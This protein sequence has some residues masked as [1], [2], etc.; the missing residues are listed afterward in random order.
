M[1]KKERWGKK[2]KDKRDWKIYNEELVIRGE[3]YFEFEFLENW[4]KELDEM[5][6]GKA[7]HPYRYPN[8]LFEYL[9]PMYCFLDSRKLEGALRK[10]SLYVRKLKSCDHSTIC[11]RLSKLN[12]QIQ[13]DKSKAYDIIFDS[14]GNK[15]TNRGEYMRHKWKVYRGWIKVSITI[16]KKSKDLLDVEVSLEN[17]ED[18]ELAR[19]HLTNLE[20]IKINSGTGD[21]AYYREELYNEFDRRG[22]IPV[23]KPRSDACPNGLDPMHKAAREFHKLGGYGE[24]RDKYEYGKRWHVEGKISS[25]KRCNGECVRMLNEENFL[26]EAKRKFTDYERMR[27]YAQERIKLLA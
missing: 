25:T 3:F 16:D 18:Y 2:F 27:K 26:K 17:V 10:L 19:K 21:G 11:E 6:K 22:I 24:W 14:T 1:P 15:L 13:L 7:G 8:S 5:N 23:L 20:E 9:S 12:P 4:D